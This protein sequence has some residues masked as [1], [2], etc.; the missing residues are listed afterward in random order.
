MAVKYNVVE[1]TI[2][3]IFIYTKRAGITIRVTTINKEAIE[4]WIFYA[5]VAKYHMNAHTRSIKLRF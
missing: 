3:L 5:F 4:F 2:L 1:S